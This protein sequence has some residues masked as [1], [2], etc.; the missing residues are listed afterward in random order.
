MKR[1][2]ASF[3][4]MALVV[5]ASALAQS[6]GT[7]VVDTSGAPVGTVTAIQGDNLTIR[8][9]KHEV[10]L[11]R[12]SMTADNGKL[13]LGLTR[14]QLN[15]QIEQ[16]LAAANAAVAPG[17][18]VNGIGGTKIGTI[19][20]IGEGKVTIALESGRKLVLPV[21]AVRGNADGTTTIGYTSAQIEELVKANSG[22]ETAE[23]AQ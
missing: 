10:V 8:T 6:V 7:Q 20:S 15:A 9:D 21:N 14:V 5:S 4:A 3:S 13:L 19:E 1:V 11:P 12:S 17:V 23:S 18:V 2:L 16:A 22:A